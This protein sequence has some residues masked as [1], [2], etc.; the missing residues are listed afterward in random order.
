MDWQ[1]IKTAPKDGSFVFLL[2]YEHG[3]VRAMGAGVYGI[4]DGYEDEPC[5]LGFNQCKKF[6]AEPTHWKSVGGLPPRECRDC[7]ELFT[8]SFI[9]RFDPK[10][11][12]ACCLDGA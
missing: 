9:A 1:P 5:W 2:C 12:E 7:G 10:I 8:P 4:R 3:E 11:C 6:P